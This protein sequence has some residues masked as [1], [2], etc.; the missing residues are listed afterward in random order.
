MENNFN[1]TNIHTNLLA[2]NN[3]IRCMFKVETKFNN[4]FHKSGSW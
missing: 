4:Y 3:K 2:Y 1:K